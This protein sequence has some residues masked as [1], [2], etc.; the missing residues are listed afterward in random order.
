MDA[1]EQQFGKDMLTYAGDALPEV[2]RTYKELPAH[3]LA[4]IQDRHQ[5]INALTEQV[6]RLTDE[7]EKTKQ[8]SQQEVAEAQRVQA[9]AEANLR[10]T[11]EEFTAYRNQ[12]NQEKGQMAQQVD[13]TRTALTDLQSKSQQEIDTLQKQVKNRDLIIDRRDEQLQEVTSTTF[14]VPD[15]KITWVNPKTGI[16]YL[17][18]GRADGLRRQVTFSVYGVDVNNLAREETKGAIEVTRV[19]DDH[20]SE[21]RITQDDLKQPILP[22]DVIYTPLWNSQSALHFALVGVMDINGDGQDDREIIRRLIQVN[23]G[24]IDA[25]DVDGEIKGKVTNRTRYL[26]RGEVPTV[27]DDADAATGASQDAWTQMMRQATELGVEQMSI[28]KLLDFVGYDGEKRTIPLG[29]DARPEDFP[30]EPD[31]GVLRSSTGNVFR[32]RGS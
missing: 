16:V 25:E 18:L 6:N 19:V 27:S 13:Q 15:G 17:N 11:R 20:L 4:T 12:L 14:E 8:Q 10:K 1:I 7:L 29:R 21:A 30:A 23:N 3:L 32:A 2:Q 22:G 28:D 31:G 24:T 5:R 26:V 9:E